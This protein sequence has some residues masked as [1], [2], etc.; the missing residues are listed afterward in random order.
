M[1]LVFVN[2][3]TCAATYLG[4]ESFNDSVDIMEGQQVRPAIKKFFFSKIN[5]LSLHCSTA[6][7]RAYNII[8]AMQ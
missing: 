3:D 4:L 5:A 7:K 2:K 8:P 6:P 1:K